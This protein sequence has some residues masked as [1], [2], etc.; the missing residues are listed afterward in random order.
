MATKWILVEP[1]GRVAQV[2]LTQAECFPVHPDLKWE[3]VTDS[4]VDDDAVVFV[5]EQDCSYR[6]G[7][8]TERPCRKVER[9][10]EA[11]KIDAQNL[12]AVQG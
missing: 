3:E 2:V 10:I 12:E 8:L 5:V 4:P 9:A 7:K 11:A 1:N 6:N